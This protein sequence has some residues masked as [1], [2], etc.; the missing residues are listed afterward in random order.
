VHGLA[1]IPDHAPNRELTERVYHAVVV[2][3][4]LVRVLERMPA[5]RVLGWG[6]LGEGCRVGPGFDGRAAPTTL[7]KPLWSARLAQ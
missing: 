4:P 6:A 7:D 3:S 5:R 2:I 1:L